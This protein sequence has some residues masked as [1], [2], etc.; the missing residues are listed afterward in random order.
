[1]VLKVG[2]ITA[3]QDAIRSR[4]NPAQF[5]GRRWLVELIEGRIASDQCRHVLIIG[6]PGSGK[7]ALIAYLAQASNWPRHFIRVDNIGGVTGTDPRHFLISVGAQ[8]Y[9][10]YGS[11]IFNQSGGT[12]SVTVGFAKDRAEIVGRFIDELVT[13]PFLPVE[14]RDVQVRAAVATGQ[15]RVIGERIGRLVNAAALLDDKTLLHLAVLEPL[16]TLAALDP[17]ERVVLLIDA[18]DEARYHSGSSV[19]SV[20][21]RPSDTDF[22]PNLRVVMTSR[23]DELLVGFRAEDIISLDEPEYASL[24]RADIRE[25][26]SARLTEPELHKRLTGFDT[27]ETDA[28]I[29]RI[30]RYS[31]GNFLYVV[32]LFNE[33]AAS[34]DED[35][36]EFVLPH[37]LDEIYRVFAV[38]KIRRSAARVNSFETLPDGVY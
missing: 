28:Y 27:A 24:N 6:E 29:S 26:I 17:A 1:M 4:F 34:P 33:L 12:I 15:T 10:K 25:Y 23:P 11:V 22:P 16:K 35:L 3:A 20:I 19:L 7:S 18:L 2:L 38:E 36:R 8:L 30:E 31:E 13:L 9:Q 14:T 5:V 21:P 37:G 32:H